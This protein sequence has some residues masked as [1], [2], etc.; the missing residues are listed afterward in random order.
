MS[1]AT[2]NHPDSTDSNQYPVKTIYV[3]G[4]L[5]ILSTM[6]VWA[7]NEFVMTK[8]IFRALAGNTQ[9][10][11]RVDMQYETVRR[12]NDWG[13]VFAPVQTTLRIGFVALI[14]QM[15]C[16]LGGKEIPFGRIFRISAI[17][18][19]ATL[20][21]SLLQIF[22]IVRQPV[23]AITQASLGIVPDSMAAWLS[24][25]SAAPSLLYLLLSRVSITSLLWMLL[26]YWGLLE[27]NRLR[28]FGA[29]TAT[30]VTWCIANA[31]Q[32]GASLFVRELVS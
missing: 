1:Q 5:T 4:L 3:F 31:V 14:V 2:D 18:F 17:A 32:I 25:T 15:T 19:G 9:N 22:W 28:W 8:E 12:M 16:L 13:Y 24:T 26:L 6:L 11:F 20:F 30:A 10:S 23:T 7:N 21:G 29:A 27:T